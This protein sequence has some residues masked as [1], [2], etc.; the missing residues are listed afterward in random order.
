MFDGVS[1]YVGQSKDIQG[2][3]KAHLNEARK[4]IQKSWK[5]RMQVV[6]RFATN[7]G[8]DAMRIME[9]YVMDVLSYDERVLKNGIQA[10]D[11]KRGRLRR[12]YGQFMRKFC[13]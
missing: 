6:A 10:I 8:K 13:K 1:F 7:G 5:S 3:Y 9:Q 11:M 12:Q 4:D 2:R